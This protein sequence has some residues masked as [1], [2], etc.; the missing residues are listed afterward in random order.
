MKIYYNNKT[1]CSYVCDKNKKK[2]RKRKT[3][4][5]K[6]PPVVEP[7]VVEPPV[8]EPPVVEPPVNTLTC[9]LFTHI[10]FDK[11]N[12]GA[13]Q[14]FG[15]KDTIPKINRITTDYRCLPDMQLKININES[16]N[17][18][19]TMLWSRISNDAYETGDINS[20]TA[21]NEWLYHNY[22]NP[23]IYKS[24]AQGTDNKSLYYPFY[25]VLGSSQTMDPIDDIRYYDT[26]NIGN[27]ASPSGSFMNYIGL[28]SPLFDNKSSEYTILGTILDNY[29]ISS[30][31]SNKLLDN[32]KNIY[33][34][35]GEK[36]IF[37]N[38]LLPESLSSPAGLEDVT[39]IE[40]IDTS[41]YKS[42]N[43]SYI[44]NNQ[45]KLKYTYDQSFCYME[46]N[47][48]IKPLCMDIINYAI[49]PKLTESDKKILISNKLKEVLTV[50]VDYIMDLSNL[51]SANLDMFTDYVDTS[52]YIRRKLSNSE[53]N[54]VNKQ[55]KSL[56][57]NNKG[58][59]Y[60]RNISNI[61]RKTIWADCTLYLKN[62]IKNTY[63]PHIKN[64]K[65]ENIHVQLD[66]EKLE[67]EFFTKKI[68]I[69]ET[70]AE[71]PIKKIVA[72]L[73]ESYTIIDLIYA[74]AE[75]RP[76]ISTDPLMGPVMVAPFFSSK[77]PKNPDD[78]KK[79]LLDSAKAG[80]IY[81]GPNTNLYNTTNKAAKYEIY[82]TTQEG[83]N[84]VFKPSVTDYLSYLKDNYMTFTPADN[85]QKITTVLI[86]L[87][88][89][90]NFF[91]YSKSIPYNMVIQYKTDLYTLNIGN[92][93]GQQTY[94]PFIDNISAIKMISDTD[95]T[96]ISEINTD[97]VF[98]LKTT[99]INQKIVDPNK[100][101]IS[102]TPSGKKLIKLFND[103]EFLC[104]WTYTEYS[105]YLNIIPSSKM[106]NLYGE[107]NINDIITGLFVKDPNNLLL[108]VK[109][110]TGNYKAKP[111]VNN[112]N[113][114]VYIHKLTDAYKI[115]FN[116]NNF[117]CGLSNTSHLSSAPSEKQSYGLFKIKIDIKNCSNDITEIESDNKSKKSLLN[118]QSISYFYLS[119]ITNQLK[120]NI[121][122]LASE[123]TKYGIIYIQPTSENQ[124][125]GKS[126]WNIEYGLYCTID[127]SLFLKQNI[128]KYVN[129]I[130]NDI[131]TYLY[132]FN[133]KNPFVFNGKDF[134]LIAIKY[135]SYTSIDFDSKY[136]ADS[137]FTKS[138]IGA[139]FNQI[140]DISHEALVAK[141]FGTTNGYDAVLKVYAITDFNIDSV[142]Y[143]IG[144]DDIKNN[145]LIFKS[146]SKFYG[147]YYGV[148]QDPLKPNQSI[149]IKDNNTIKNISIVKKT[150]S[151]TY[152]FGKLDYASSYNL[153]LIMLKSAGAA[154]IPTVNGNDLFNANLI[155]FY[156]QINDAYTQQFCNYNSIFTT[157]LQTGYG[158]SPSPT[159]TNNYICA[160]NGPSLLAIHQNNNLTYK[161]KNLMNI[162]VG[163]PI[164]ECGAYNGIVRAYPSC[165]IK[166]HEGAVKEFEKQKKASNVKLK[167][168]KLWDNSR[169][170]NNRQYKNINGALMFWAIGSEATI[171]SFKQL[172]TIIPENCVDYD[173]INDKDYNPQ[174]WFLYKLA[175]PIDN[176]IEKNKYK[177]IL[178]NKILFVYVDNVSNLQANSINTIYHTMVTYP[179]P[180]NLNLIYAFATT[181]KT[182]NINGNTCYDIF[183]ST[184]DSKGIKTKSTAPLWGYTQIQ[185]LNSILKK[186]GGI[187]KMLKLDV[188]KESSR[189]LI[190]RDGFIGVWLDY[191]AKINTKTNNNII[192]TSL[193]RSTNNIGQILFSYGGANEGVGLTSES[194]DPLILGKMLALACFK[195]NFDGV[196]LDLEGINKTNE[197]I[198]WLSALHYS[199]KSTF[200]IIEYFFLSKE[201]DCKAFNYNTNHKFLLTDAPQPLYFDHT[202]YG[203]ASGLNGYD[204]DVLIDSTS[205]NNPILFPN[206]EYTMTYNDINYTDC[207]CMRDANSKITCNTKLGTN[208][209]GVCA[210]YNVGNTS[211]PSNCNPY[212][213]AMKP[214]K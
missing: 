39:N 56:L 41:N 15:P 136:I 161:N 203:A 91:N 51:I 85:V 195:N 154:N 129:I 89:I 94:M 135:E 76:T 121:N 108:P 128:T 104:L 185:H 156:N 173:H 200:L 90:K 95:L 115:V 68:Y 18:Y 27:F 42:F 192:I 180:I 160:G 157:Y 3:Q 102:N 205:N 130:L 19:P 202:Y 155:Q 138:T 190:M 23:I 45:F 57:G 30:K 167:D 107:N 196:D 20:F 137:I 54:L 151:E 111:G 87:N 67:P 212:D 117:I 126:D 6:R 140:N 163:K 199:I 124:N 4:P 182:S 53:V 84:E 92:I 63:L 165:Y 150:V 172:G 141:P 194:M 99:V 24:D 52:G 159:A 116:G 106:R 153:P 71:T 114:G 132:S 98:N 86:D 101:Y 81:W 25:Q 7:P 36:I 96:Q 16:L 183:N 65:Q 70:F 131:S 49:N 145:K 211:S 29:N 22:N 184:V 169:M 64:H 179:I 79:Y 40:G 123:Q 139:E 158:R 213:P 59:V 170:G 109:N 100:L 93:N 162:A 122:N 204:T 11:D 46:R 146:S 142:A 62:Y 37:N 32:I 133:L 174:N 88:E 175:T 31:L 50:D 152:F 82:K 44:G 176:T 21:F 181:E 75:G 118:Y 197:Q 48:F 26:P 66:G 12:S 55:L 73:V 61:K 105:L 69:S 1:G 201:G 60:R 210:N 72:E 149:D 17:Y 147:G 209:K 188:L 110:F 80:G 74:Y 97:D 187:K 193:N 14:F 43:Q 8:V 113:K 13:I 112:F 206:P 144:N 134:P 143:N 127:D 189:Q 177:N 148:T 171:P 208:P 168:Y 83:G 120:Q 214:K 125:V 35:Y 28:T 47:N 164:S 77:T 10:T 2:K 207:L 33:N 34:L 58:T 186:H 5:P 166:W 178:A 191:I 78:I 198:G 119:L 103:Y 38:N 9:S